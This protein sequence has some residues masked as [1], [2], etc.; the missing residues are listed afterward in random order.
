[1][2]G[3]L[4]EQRQLSGR[5]YERSLQQA[6]TNLALDQARAKM[7]QDTGSSLSSG[8]SAGA[9]AYSKFAQARDTS[10]TPLSSGFY[11]GEIGAANAYGVAP[12]QLS[13]QKPTG[14]FMGIGG[15]GGGYYYTPGGVFGR[16]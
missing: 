13:Y 6:E 4:G 10:T 8:I 11:Q 16:K 15:Q 1:M 9:G 5:E 7:I 3:L 12:S 14:G 2:S